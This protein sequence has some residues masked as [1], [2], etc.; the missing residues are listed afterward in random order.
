MRVCFARRGT[1]NPLRCKCVAGAPPRCP[2]QLKCLRVDKQTE[3]QGLDITQVRLQLSWPP[4]SDPTLL[5]PS[6]PAQNH[7]D[8]HTRPPSQP[9]PACLQGI[10][11][12]IRGSCL[13][14]LPCFRS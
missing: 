2:A 1:R 5:V 10:G 6:H 12:G 11:T 4:D 9:P 14:G 13:S 3:Q 7:P 8:H